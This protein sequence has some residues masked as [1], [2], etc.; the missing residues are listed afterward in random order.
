MRIAPFPLAR[1]LVLAA[2][3]LAAGAAS[4][5]AQCWSGGAAGAGVPRES[6]LVINQAPFAVNVMAGPVNGTRRVLGQVPAKS[7]M[8]FLG[9]LPPGRNETTVWADAA[10]IEQHKLPAA[11]VSGMVTIANRGELTCR[12]AAQM[13]V[14]TG[15]FAAAARRRGTDVART[16]N[17]AELAPGAGP[18]RPAARRPAAPP[19]QPGAPGGGAGIVRY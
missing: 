3:V 4:A 2:A 6:L 14:T 9:V 17:P 18:R 12:R 5:A 19:R 7:T 16:R 10:D 13:T 8:R 1:N 11:R 15:V